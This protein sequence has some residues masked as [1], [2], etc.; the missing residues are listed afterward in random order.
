MLKIDEIADPKSC[1]NI[2]KDSE[3]VFVLLG[4][5]IAAPDT[6]RFWCSERIRLGKNLTTDAQITEALECASLMEKERA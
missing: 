1:L 2:A 6:I 3:R 5:D 4:R